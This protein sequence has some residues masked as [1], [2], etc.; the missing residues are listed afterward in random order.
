MAKG[1]YLQLSSHLSLLSAHRRLSIIVGR[2]IPPPQD[3]NVLIPKACDYGASHSNRKFAGV[4][5]L[6][7]LRHPS[8]IFTYLTS[9]WACEF[10]WMNYNSLLA[11]FETQIALELASGRPFNLAPVSFWYVPFI[12]W[13]LPYF[14]T[15]KIFQLVCTFPSPV[16]ESGIPPM[17]PGSLYSETKIWVLGM[18]IAT[19]MS[20][21][22]G[23]L[24]RQN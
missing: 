14:I 8:Y 19:G 9:V 15:S 23:P 21:L 24:G 16:L 6:R 10:H 4:I 11:Y 7:I 2:I 3:A 5:N 22:P 1:L 20:L 17:S 12:P 18:L 13:G